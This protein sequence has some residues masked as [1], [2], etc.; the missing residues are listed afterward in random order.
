MAPDDVL[1]PCVLGRRIDPPGCLQLVNLPQP[2]Q[3]R[4]I[5][6]HPF[7]GFA[8]FNDR[9]KGDIPVNWIVTEALSLEV[10]HPGYFDG[11]INRRQRVSAAMPQ[12]MSASRLA[13]PRLRSIT[14]SRVMR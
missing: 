10:V 11:A 5:E 13:V 1:K 6:Q 2:L 14:E 7:A 9:R 4:M 12:A 8:R 3:P